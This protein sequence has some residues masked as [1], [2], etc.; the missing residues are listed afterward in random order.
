MSILQQF[1]VKKYWGKIFDEGYDVVCP[2]DI[3][4]VIIK[5][6]EL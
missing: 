4:L 6:Y 1:C 3:F 5:F 2:Y